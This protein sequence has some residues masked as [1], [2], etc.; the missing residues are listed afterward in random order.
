MNRQYSEEDKILHVE[1]F[2]RAGQNIGEFTRANDIPESTF[3]E[4][5][6]KDGDMEFGKIQINQSS[7]SAAKLTRNTMIF[8]CENIRIELKENFNKDLLKQMVEVMINA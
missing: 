7:T 8:V 6:K 1:E 2:K 4:W 5:L 3:R